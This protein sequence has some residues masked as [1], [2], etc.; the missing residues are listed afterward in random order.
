VLLENFPI[1]RK[2]L[3]FL[4]ACKK[5][6]GSLELCQVGHLLNMREEAEYEAYFD[7]R[8]CVI[9]FQFV[10]KEGSLG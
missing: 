7:S 8:R 9:A 3:V 5:S 6:I 2:E 4:L 10:M 1:L